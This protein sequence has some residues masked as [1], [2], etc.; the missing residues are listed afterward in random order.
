[1]NRG[2]WWL[3][4]ALLS[5]GG[6]GRVA[7]QVLRDAQDLKD[8]IGP[9]VF[10]TPAVSGMSRSK[11]IIV[12]YETLPSYGIS[13]RSANPV[14][15]SGE[16]KLRHNERLDLRLFVP[17]M[18][19]PALKAV[20]GLQY[21]LESF[22]FPAGTDYP[23]YTNLEDRRFRVLGGQVVVLHSFAERSY[24][25]VRVKGSLNGDYNSLRELNITRYM[26]YSMEAVYGW[27]SG[28][29]RSYGGALQITHNFGRTTVLPAIIF[30]RTFSEKWGM[31]AV[32]PAQVL[33]RRNVSDKTLLFMG[34]GGESMR[35]NMR[36]DNPSFAGVDSLQLRRIDIRGRLRWEQ[37]IHDFLWFGLESGLQVNLRHRA[38]DQ[39]SER[40]RN[41]LIFSRTQPTPYLRAE[42]FLVPPRRFS[43]KR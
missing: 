24:A 1:M 13:S 20:V 27:Q 7:G 35:Y 6:G 31:E 14:V 2:L 43:K 19:K 32:F 33:F 17:F 5:L 28:P 16:A 8:I 25:V 12:R 36:T 41:A 22:D 37:E 42:I 29:N 30:N 38:L 3:V 23:F 21:S 18:N 39:F 10:A 9:R 11:G 34:Y 4:V 15:G 26:R 40:S